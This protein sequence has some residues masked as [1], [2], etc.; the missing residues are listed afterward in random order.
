MPS[1]TRHGIEGSY[2]PLASQRDLS[3]RIEGADGRETLKKLF[4]ISPYGSK[5]QRVLNRLWTQIKTGS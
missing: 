2:R 3:W 1:T 4:T 5:E